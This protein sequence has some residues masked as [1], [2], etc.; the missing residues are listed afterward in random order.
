M[1]RPIFRL[2]HKWIALTRTRIN[3]RDSFLAIHSSV[4]IIVE[5]G[6]TIELNDALVRI[7]FP[8]PTVPPFATI[9]CSRIFVG[10]NA[11]LIFN[12]S[13][14]I[15]PGA[16]IRL[17]ENST[18]TFGGKN[19][20]AHNLTV[21]CA[22]RIEIGPDVTFSWNVTLIDDDGHRFQN[23]KGRRVR[24]FYRPIILAKNSRL[25]MNVI[26]PRGVTVGENSVVSCGTILRSDVPAN[27]IA[28][29]E[30]KMRIKEG[31]SA[32]YDFTPSASTL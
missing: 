7:G 16:T 18:L 17:K 25:Q 19:H 4:E 5:K 30:N 14:L 8:L 11:K 23:G 3:G 13:A 22:R 10:R 31:L 32:P 27:C 28:Y 12:G 24:F 2:I 20:I 29:Q 1:F 26:I 15:A 9:P 21:L 6:A